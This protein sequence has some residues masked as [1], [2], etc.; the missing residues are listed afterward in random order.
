MKSGNLNFL[1]LSGPLQA[2]NGTAL[3]AFR[4]CIEWEMKMC[5]LCQKVVTY[6]GQ[7]EINVASVLSTNKLFNSVNRGSRSLASLSNC[8][9]RRVLNDKWQEANEELSF[10]KI[11]TGNNTA[12]WIH[13]YMISNVVW[14]P[15]E[16]NK[17]GLER[18]QERLFM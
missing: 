8:T 3:P 14:K 9:F 6:S 17:L 15:D 16:V 5:L 12:G 13:P 18:E 1:E 7:S 10:K 2:C 11:T 4:C